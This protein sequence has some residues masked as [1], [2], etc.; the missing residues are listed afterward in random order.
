MKRPYPLT[1]TL[2]AFALVTV[3]APATRA[4]ASTAIA[5]SA[6]AA[7]V[8]TR[9]GLVDRQI[10]AIDVG[11]VESGNRGLGFVVTAHL[12]KAEALGPPGVTIHDDLNGLNATMRREHLLQGAIG[13]AVG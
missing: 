2:L 5:A 10:A 11:A 13:Y 1:G 4:A 3:A 9:L 7:P 6:T 8:L 12:D